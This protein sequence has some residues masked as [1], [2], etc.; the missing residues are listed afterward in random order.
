MTSTLMCAA[1][2]SH[3]FNSCSLILGTPFI[4]LYVFNILNW[5]VLHSVI[6]LNITCEVIRFNHNSSDNHNDISINVAGMMVEKLLESAAQ[7]DELSPDRSIFLKWEP[8]P[9]SIVVWCHTVFSRII[10][11]WISGL[12]SYINSSLTSS[13]AIHLLPNE[14]RSSPRCSPNSRI[15]SPLV[16]A[17]PTKNGIANVPITEDA[18]ACLMLRHVE[19]TRE[20]H[21]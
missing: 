18:A 21:V 3:L 4:I 10:C 7:S 8:N 1:H 11:S 17:T 19:V 20:L 14:K 9:F 2:E 16:H 5:C 6:L 12:A 15:A 13:V